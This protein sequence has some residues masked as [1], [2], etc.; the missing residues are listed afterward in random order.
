MGCT[1]VG[2]MSVLLLLPTLHWLSLSH[3][4]PLNCKGSWE[5]QPVCLRVGMHNII[6]SIWR[7]PKLTLS[8]LF[9][10]IPRDA[11]NNGNFLNMESSPSPWLLIIPR[12]AVDIWLS[13]LSVGVT[14][15]LQK[16]SLGWSPIELQ[17]G[18]FQFV[19]QL[20]SQEVSMLP[21]SQL[22]FSHSAFLLRLHHSATTPQN[23]SGMGQM[24]ISVFL[25]LQET[26]NKLS[27]NL[28]NLLQGRKQF[29]FPPSSK[30]DRTHSTGNSLSPVISLD[31]SFGS[32]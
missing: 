28:Q 13:T 1:L 18:S 16:S 5:M 25:H 8:G 20:V 2:N 9:S 19:P 12:K 31:H 14:L 27:C 21:I 3:M 15:P 32:H 26:C 7:F 29:S 24:Q 6:S 23:F 30:E 11:P 10:R 4:I 17:A 22:Q